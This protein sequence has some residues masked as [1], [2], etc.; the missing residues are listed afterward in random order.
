[1]NIFKFLTPLH[2]TLVLL[3]HETAFNNPVICRYA[4]YKLLLKKDLVRN[5]L[6]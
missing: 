5:R 1:M 4:L 6:K 2:C 3:F